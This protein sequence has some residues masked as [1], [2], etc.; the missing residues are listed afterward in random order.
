[1]STPARA[2]K[3]TSIS[4]KAPIE[5]HLATLGRDCRIIYDGADI[6]DQIH[7]LTLTATVNSNKDPTTHVQLEGYN[8]DKGGIISVAGHHAANASIFG[9]FIPRSVIIEE[10]ITPDLFDE[11]TELPT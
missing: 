8:E 6:S 10:E 1:M 5:I 11:T 4:T 9:E 2:L 7:S 3:F